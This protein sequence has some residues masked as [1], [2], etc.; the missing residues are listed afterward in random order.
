MFKKLTAISKVLIF[1]SLAVCTFILVA[2]IRI[3]ALK[4]NDIPS[5]IKLNINGILTVVIAHL[6]WGLVIEISMNVIKIGEKLGVKDDD[7]V[8]RSEDV[9]WR[10]AECGNTN[11]TEY[12][13]CQFCGRPK[14]ENQNPGD[15]APW[16][17]SQCGSLSP[18]SSAYCMNCGKPKSRY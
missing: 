14:N 4:L 12:R 6:V 13:F 8:I 17:C 16:K 3:D 9:P 2:Y 1:V 18:A 11:S 10:C 5:A 7:D 15:N